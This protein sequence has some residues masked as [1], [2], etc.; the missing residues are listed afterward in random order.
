[1]NKIV[2]NIKFYIG[3]FMPYL[4]IVQLGYQEVNEGPTCGW[5]EGRVD[6]KLSII[7]KKTNPT[8]KWKRKEEEQTRKTS[9]CQGPITW[10]MDG[11]QDPY[12]YALVYSIPLSSA[13]ELLFLLLTT[14]R[15]NSPESL[16]NDKI[17]ITES[18]SLTKNSSNTSIILKRKTK[19]KSFYSHST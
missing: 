14:R 10:S 17:I 4:G 3:I 1:M 2:E 12:T 15:S 16:N 8:E 7:N 19:I 9:S 13:L 6:K 11:R 5:E 18:P